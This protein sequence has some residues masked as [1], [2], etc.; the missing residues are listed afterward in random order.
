M[1][2]LIR[3][4]MLLMIIALFGGC[5]VA[6]PNRVYLK[7][8]LGKDFMLSE[9]KGSYKNMV[10][11]LPSNLKDIREI[12]NYRGVY[13]TLAKEIN[14]FWSPF[15]NLKLL[16]DWDNNANNYYNKENVLVRIKINDYALNAAKD[17]SECISIATSV[18]IF[19]FNEDSQFIFDGS[20]CY[21]IT[22]VRFFSQPYMQYL[23]V[24]WNTEDYRTFVV[25]YMS[26][27]SVHYSDVVD[28]LM[29]F[30]R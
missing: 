24:G 30:S 29:G 4:I 13:G 8:Y 27:H 25:E 17:S 7:S 15:K 18:S 22:D 14:S 28:K 11:L 26:G 6:P 12:S 23:K 10:L 3:F 5:A 21:G 20:N 9:E 16:A 2:N 19:P 1:R